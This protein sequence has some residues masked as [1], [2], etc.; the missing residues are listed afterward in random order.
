M[1]PQ[2]PESN[3]SNQILPELIH[4]FHIDTSNNSEDLINNL[5]PKYSSNF[6][7]LQR[8]AAYVLRFINKCRRKSSNSGVLKSHELTNSLHFFC[9]L[10]QRESFPEEYYLLSTGK[11]LPAKNKLL[12]LSPFFDK[13]CNLMRVGGRLSN[14]FYDF[15]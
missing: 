2:F 9:N 11:Q 1:W 8:I 6:Y 13:T 10:S 5:F 12:S 7:S 14:S 15:M 3:H 4:S